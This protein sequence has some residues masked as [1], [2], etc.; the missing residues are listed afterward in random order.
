MCRW[1][2][3]RH[4]C[5]ERYACSASYLT[6]LRGRVTVDITMTTSIGR[7]TMHKKHA[8]V[9]KKWREQNDLSQEAVAR[10]AAVS[11]STVRNWLKNK[12]PGP[13]MFQ[14]L[15]LDKSH[16]GLSRMLFGD[17]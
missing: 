2:S 9:L 12:G 10:I 17:D 4:I 15:L 16:P 11:L 5:F 3:L 6:F 14:I 8:A 1:P 13:T 7:E